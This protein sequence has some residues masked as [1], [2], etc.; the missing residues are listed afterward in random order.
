MCRALFQ[1]LEDV[2]SYKAQI[3]LLS[4]FKFDEDLTVIR[5]IKHNFLSKKNERGYLLTIKTRLIGIKLSDEFATCFHFSLF[6]PLYY[7]FFR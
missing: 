4:D 6:C 7:S 1:I 2:K 5:Y 3:L